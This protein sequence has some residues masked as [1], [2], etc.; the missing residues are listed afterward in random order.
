MVG[1]SGEGSAAALEHHKVDIGREMA[2]GGQEPGLFAGKGD[3]D[4]EF[5]GVWQQKF[6]LFRVKTKKLD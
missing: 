6:F 1:A 5:G 3:D 4:F 2:E